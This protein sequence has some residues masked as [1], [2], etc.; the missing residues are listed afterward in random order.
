MQGCLRNQL[1]DISG[2]KYGLLTAIEFS[3]IGEDKHSVWVFQCD[4]GNI[5]EKRKCHVV[6]H[7]IRSCGCL[8]NKVR[9]NNG[10][11]NKKHGMK[12]TRLY[13]IW[14]G[15]RNRCNNPKSCNARYYYDRGITICKEW[16][17]FEAFYE[18]A[19]ENGYQDNLSIDRINNDKG[20]SPENC[21]WAT[22][23][24]QVLNR[25]KRA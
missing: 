24:E 17:S 23:R 18:W 5:V 25:R 19:M 9:A 20:Y 12:N 21:R 7:Q 11:K 13:R 22:A 16:D 8:Q 6:S 2:N 15:M 10:R 14:N 1:E 4:C 3:H